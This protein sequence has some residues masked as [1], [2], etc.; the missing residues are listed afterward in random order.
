MTQPA[1]CLLTTALCGVIGSA[2]ARD[3][4]KETDR[5]DGWSGDFS[6][7]YDGSRAR[8]NTL[9]AGLEAQWS[10]PRAWI[11][12]SGDTYSDLASS[13]DFRKD[14]YATLQLGY[15]LYKNNEERLYWNA[16]LEIDPHSQ[17]A[18]RGWDLAPSMDVAYGLTE[19]WWIGCDVG[20]V[21]STR[22]DEGDHAGFLSQT[23]WIYWLCGF[24][25]EETDALSLSLW[26]AG[27][28]VPG[29][30]H[31]L[32]AE[33]E[34]TFDLTDNL[35]AAIGVGTDIMSQWDHLGVYFSAGLKWSF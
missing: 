32:F 4:L 31:N 5:K 7:D 30:D 9:H 6:L 14:S 18:S 10:T 19:D 2:H 24:T 35:E 34:Y 15:A 13:P 23:L 17:L 26:A 1:R 8:T 22:P 28:E 29:G 20:A 27:N 33:L 21:L 3:P 16:K 11:S 25:A 12:L